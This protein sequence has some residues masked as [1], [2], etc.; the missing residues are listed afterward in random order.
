M[1][2]VGRELSYAEHL[3]LIA[4]RVPVSQFGLQTEVPLRDVP[5]VAST[6]N[7]TLRSMQ[8]FCDVVQRRSFSLAAGDNGI[9]QSSASQTVHHL[10]ERLGVQLLDR[11]KRPFVLTPE[12]ERYYDGCRQLV[13]LH[14]KLEDEIHA[15]RDET[16]RRLSVA[17]IYSVGLAHMSALMER[18][19]TE[20][21]GADVRLDYMHPAQVNEA[22]EQGE[23]DLGL[24]SFPEDS[25]KLVATAWRTESLVLVCHPRHRLAKSESIELG[26][27]AGESFVALKTNLRLRAEIDRELLVE[28]VEIHV[29]HELDNIEH[30]KRDIETGAG[31]SILPA[32]TVQ[33]EVADGT[34]VSVP[35][36]G[37]PLER[38]LGIIH[39]RGVELSCIALQF[40][41][42][43][44]ADGEF[45]CTASA[46][47]N[48]KV[49]QL[50]QQR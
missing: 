43:L 33:R 37:T 23:V 6:M 4:R 35:V 28:K 13:R 50:S 5:V 32:P 27:L 18:F 38:P 22:V 48:G 12:G 2:P 20:Y 46:S 1:L 39:R 21:P 16:A 47:A 49:D 9:A 36:K 3:H 40:I 8:I 11:S 41:E 29:A 25:R 45:A 26:E 10:E 19:K 30:I 7:I 24:V 31:V 17:S 14:Q 42:M 15:L 34:L 44:Q